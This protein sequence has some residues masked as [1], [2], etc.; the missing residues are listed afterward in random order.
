MNTHPSVFRPL[1]AIL[2]LTLLAGIIGRVHGQGTL[3]D[4]FNDCNDDGWTR[5]GF[6]GP[7]GNWDASFMHAGSCAY[8]LTNLPATF[9]AIAASWDASADTR[10]SDG[11]FQ[12]TVRP[13]SQV[14]AVIMGMRTVP[15]G[16]GYLGE[17]HLDQ[18]IMRIRNHGVEGAQFERKLDIDANEDWYMQIGTIEDQFSLKAWRVGEPEPNSP[19]LTATYSTR[20]EGLFTIA[21]GVPPGAPQ[22]LGNA[23][24][25]DIHF[26]VPFDCNRDGVVD[27]TDLQCTATTAGLNSLL[28]ELNL[29]KGDFDGVGGVAF[30]DFLVLADNFGQEVDSYALG[31]IDLNGTVEFADFLVLADNFGLGG[32]AAAVPEPSS[33]ALFT[34]GTLLMGLVR[35]R[36]NY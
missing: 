23:V 17:L 24:F 35:R 13:E 22:G 32:A 9:T 18:G 3:V 2:V 12:A 15:F 11:F 20:T 30:A 36:R 26:F 14:T 8:H 29:V 33:V 6:I 19:Q 21:T 10:F 5:E 7:G 16:D 1:G 25:D 4:D 27:V 31:D 28:G 34:V